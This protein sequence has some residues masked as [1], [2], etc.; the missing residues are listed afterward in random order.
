MPD[1]DLAIIGA[2][3]AGLSV[4]AQAASLGLKVA[5]FEREPPAARRPGGAVP[6]AALLAAAHRAVSLREAG[7]LGLS[8]G[9]VTVDWAALQ[10][11]LRAAA[12][13]AAPPATPAA[14]QRQGIALVEHSAHFIAPDRIEAGGRVHRFRRA[15]IAAGTAPVLPDL[16]GMVGL[17][18][19]TEETLLDLPAPPPHLLV[20]GGTPR[21]VELA[22]A[23]ARLGCRVT[24]VVP[25]P[26]LLEEEEPELRQPLREAL[27][28][29]GVEIL[30]NSPVI[31]L[32]AAATGLAA[33]VEGGG[34]LTGSHLLFA[35]GRAPRLAP[36]DLAAG[37]IRATPRGVATGADLRSL[38]N[39][40][41]W[42]AGDIADPEGLRPG[43][44]AAVHATVIAR[45]M[46]FRL[47]ARLEATAAPRAIGTSPAL[48][49]VGMTEAE[50]RAA[51]H[52]PRILRQAFAGNDQAIAEAATAGMVR[53]VVDG[54]GRLLGA[55]ILGDGAA[56]L[57]G[58]LG[59]VIG[60][61]LPLS[62]LA[63]LD[64]PRP[65]R[66]EAAVRAAQSSAGPIYP[67]APFG[68]TPAPAWA[69]RVAGWLRHLP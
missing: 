11:H 64:L 45:S 58:M 5:L 9:P 35:L 60:R 25:S 41:V 4:A 10:A 24:L 46:L 56:E 67:A 7:R 69:R 43:Q 40:R 8:A 27:R 61:Q 47:P 36:L 13:A 37:G 50:A 26:N 49:Q 63:G 6:V 15:V 1:H 59:L 55:G 42:A 62:A 57:A 28:A 23:H 31:A 38:S 34:R 21:G 53:L 29:D 48:A 20:L 22:Q 39:R 30:E 44:A 33:V 3:A 32:E 14:L 54:R 18:W 66:A 16:P 17:P 68:G 2:G 19:L 65:S 52:A 12:A 51:G